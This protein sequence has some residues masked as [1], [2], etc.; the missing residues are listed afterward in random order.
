MVCRRVL[1]YKHFQPTISTPRQRHTDRHAH[2]QHRERDQQ[3]T[4]PS[5]TAKDTRGHSLRPDIDADRLKVRLHLADRHEILVEDRRR[6]AR[7]YA[8]DVKDLRKVLR[9]SRAARGD[10]R[11]TD[12]LPHRAR[13]AQIIPVIL[14]VI[15]DAIEEELAAAERLDR[16]CE[17][18]DV[19]ARALPTALYGTLVPA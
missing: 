6:E 14:A 1:L 11:N 16:A 15:V 9:H 5:R 19:Q 2:P 17:L 7:L 13:E 10:H 3:L 4:A 12:A 8:T 18:A